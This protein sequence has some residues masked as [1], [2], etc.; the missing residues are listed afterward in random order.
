V[1]RSQVE[2]ATAQQA[3]AAA[4][5]ERTNRYAELRSLLGLP[6][7]EA[8]ALTDTLEVTPASYQ[9]SDLLAYGLEHRPELQAAEYRQA[10]LSAAA[11]AV[12][13]QSRPEL[14]WEARRANFD[15]SGSGT[16]LR[17]GVSL[18]LGDWGQHRADVQAAEAATAEQ[19]ALARETTRTA[20]VE[21]ETAYNTF[22]EAEHQVA[23][24][25]QGR[26]A[27]AQQLLRMVQLGYQQ[28]ASSYL[29]LLDAQHEYATAK[30]GLADAEATYHQALASLQ[31]AMG[32]RLPCD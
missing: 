13:A 30:A 6:A 20:K 18:A 32:G 28:G 17:V 22:M 14:F 25:R 5:V 27:L 2:V 23:S 1:V 11:E 21:I 24:Y 31:H 29:E 19:A 26:L 3:L 7:S 4:A 10:S 8:L 9:L 15:P 12:R 16:S